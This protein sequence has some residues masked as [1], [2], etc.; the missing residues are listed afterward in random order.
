[1]SMANRYL[2]PAP[3][4]DMTLLS[5]EVRNSVLTHKHIWLGFAGSMIALSVGAFLCFCFKT[6]PFPNF[7]QRLKTQGKL[8]A[9]KMLLRR[10]HLQE[11]EKA[12]DNFSPDCLVGTGAFG[13]VYRGTFD[14]NGTFAIKKARADSYTSTE[15]FKN[16]VRLLSKVRHRNLV[17]LVGFCEEPGRKGEKILVYEYVPNGSL[18]DY[19]IGRGG[20]SLSWRE[21]VNIAIG[22]AKGSFGV[23]LLQLVAARPAVDSTRSRSNY[24]II[25]WARPSLEQGNVEEI[26][27]A[28]LLLDPDCNLEMML[29]MGQL[30]LRCVAKVPKQRPTMTHVWQEL[31]SSLYSTDN[32]IYKEPSNVPGRSIRTS[33]RSTDHDYS[34]SFVSEDG[35]RL[36]RFHVEMDGLS[37]QSTSLRCFEASSVMSIDIDK[38][39]TGISEETNAY[40]D[41]DISIPRD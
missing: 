34:Q 22:A 6:K 14:E 4:P 33:R 10:F 25:E 16:E 38:N 9:E 29:K 15:E 36:Q 2:V 8:D 40:E 39:Q 23:I 21:R 18:L 28:N 12:T 37:F 26:L 13:N 31:E 11:L 41:M 30:G 1:M 35:V 27:D 7:R 3:S 19:I 24:H 32:S 5:L 20:R 17:S